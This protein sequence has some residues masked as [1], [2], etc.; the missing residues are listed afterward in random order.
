LRSFH[1]LSAWGTIPPASVEIRLAP[2]PALAGVASELLPGNPVVC[3]LGAG[4]SCR[5]SRSNSQF[6]E[7]G[8]GRNISRSAWIRGNSRFGVDMLRLV[9]TT[10]PRSGSK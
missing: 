10:Q 7:H 4:K 8:C 5:R 6:E 1:V 9:A 3:H 2:D